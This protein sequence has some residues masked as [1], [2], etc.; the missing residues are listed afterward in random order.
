MGG[1]QT[2]NEEL[3]QAL[4]LDVAKAVAGPPARQQELTGAP[5]REVSHLNTD[6]RDDPYAGSAGRLVFC[7]EIAGGGRVMTRT[8]ETSKCWEEE[9]PTGVTTFNPSIYT[10]HSSLGD[11]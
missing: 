11:A 8:W 3:N 5:A 6:E 2:L 1:D 10:E 7:A 4:K 9:G